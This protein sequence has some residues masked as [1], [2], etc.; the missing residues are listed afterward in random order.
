[1]SS[2]PQFAVKIARRKLVHTAVWVVGLVQLFRGQDLT[3]FSTEVKVV[4][5]LAT[6]RGP[7][8]EI[9]ADLAK[10][11]FQV[12]ENGRQQE[13]R[14]FSKET[15]LPLTIGLMVDTSMSQRKV[16][17]EERSASFRFLDEMLRPKD[18]VFLIQFDMG[19]QVRQPL[20]SSLKV[21]NDILPYVDTPTEK[22]LRIQTGGGTLLYDAV[23]TASQDILQKARNRKA[24]IVLSDGVDIGSEASLAQAIAAAQRADSL[25]YAILFSDPGAYGVSFAGSVGKSAMMRMARETGGSF[26]EVSKKLTIDKVYEQIQKEL[27]SQF[28][29]GYVSDD[30]VRI[31][32]F[33]KIHLAVKEKG[34]TV[35]TRQEYWA[36]R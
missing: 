6:V 28:S 30:P 9:V 17:V 31:S 4:N 32:E 20:T 7:H 18:Q 26:F 36:Q 3:T 15:D 14:Y 25:I 24:M 35:Q 11:D 33:R 2:I 12:A 27:R 13:I 22:Q 34:L 29:I 1:M 10:D 21:L 19:V 16:L 23:V 5:L 8:G